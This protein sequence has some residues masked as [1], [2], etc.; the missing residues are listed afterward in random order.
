MKRPSRSLAF[1]A[2]LSMI[3]WGPLCRAQTPEVPARIAGPILEQSR[4]RVEGN[5]PAIALAQNDRGKASGSIQL[6][7]MRVV[8][9]RSAAQQTALD[10]F[11][12]ELQDKSSPNYHKWLTPEEFGRRYGPADSD[13]AAAVAWLQSHGLAVDPLS[14]GRTNI[15]FSGA[16]SQVE[17]AFDTSIH[18]YEFNGQQ[19]YSNRTNPSIPSALAPLI[20]G[21]AHLNTWSPRPS[22]IRADP[23]RMDPASKRLVPIHNAPE[24]RPAPAFDPAGGGNLYLVPGDAATIYDTPN[25]ALNANDSSAIK[26]DGTGVTIGV[27]GTS[28]IKTNTVQN[29]RSNFLGNTVVPI[30]TNIDG[31]TFTGGNTEP[32]IDVEIAGGLAPGATIHYYVANDLLTPIEQ[33]LTDNTVDILAYTYGVCEQFDST[34]DN[35]AINKFWEQAAVQGIA[36]AVAT[37]DS[38]SAGCDDPTDSNGQDTAAAVGGLAVNA[39]AS[40]PYNIA[41]GGTDFDQLDQ[42]FSSYSTSG[43]SAATYYRTALKYIPEATWNDSTQDNNAVA[44]NQPWGVGLSIYPANIIGGGG[45]PSNCAT[46]KTAANVGSCV[47]GY[48][49]P[50]WQRGAGVP[51]DGIRDLPDVSLMAGNG[52]YNAAWLVCDD[53]TNDSTGLPDDCS[54]QS[55][56]GFNFAAYGGTSTAAPAFAGI[57]ALVQQSTGGRLGQA[58]AQLYNLYNG[59]HASQI[60][61]DVTQGN[62]SVSCTQGSPNCKKNI[63]AYYFETGYNATAGYDLATGLGS[64]DASQLISYW[65]TATSG[66]AATVTVTPVTVSI[67]ANQS[68]SVAVTVAGSGGLLAPTGT[69]ALTG[70]GYTSSAETLSNG[71]YT[72]TIPANSLSVGADALTV[73]YS[74]DTNY[75]SA[76]GTANVTVTAPPT[77]TLSATNPSV[78]APGGSAASTVTVQSSSGYTGDVTLSCALTSAPAGATNLPTCSTGSSVSLTPTV[79]TGTGSVSVT[80]TA[81]TTGSLQPSSPA[82][83]QWFRA[84]GGSAVL[85]LLI[86]FV[87]GR[88]RKW[89]HILSAWILAASIGF[90]LVGCGSSS[91]TTTGN[92]GGSSGSGGGT[93]AKTTPTVKVS[94]ASTSIVLNT[95][96]SV[97]LTVT[98]SGTTTPTG[99]ITLASGSYS[100]SA[101]TLIGG[102]ATV[103]I[104]ASTLPVGQN[105]LTASY[106]GDGNFNPA[107]GTA[108]LTVTNPP[109]VGG[110]TPG[111]YTFTV[112]GTGNDAANT[113]A[114]TTFTITVS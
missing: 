86:F 42:S 1:S 36:V 3:F 54:L 5:V 15:A 22:S 57:L 95:T 100:S 33:A 47:A 85:A 29:Y 30:I 8:L 97:A 21:I 109:L 83:L 114:T 6:K 20:Q 106:S 14:P 56:G 40:T 16:V 43:G 48:S 11:E 34:A 105:I 51:A 112:T 74:G 79:T 28:L 32:Y 58:A 31:V 103:T 23:G 59:S 91:A 67:T 49:K 24:R 72:F 45:G 98:G 92:R 94:P 104:P 80:T 37:G 96:V 18:S 27:P 110:T 2:L 77:F 46:N 71:A 81:P 41:V 4:V 76:T 84:A 53:S 61:H 55:N 9:T 73:T 90:V 7:H 102:S 75:A 108:T 44:N 65:N 69:V 111:S 82:D 26:Y 89:R 52:F 99:T 62:N 66:A 12:Q 88:T 93:A 25:P 107:S 63:A 17:E 101:A 70:G 78:A 64:V 39:Y 19:F 113:S 10:R 87:P 60:F 35:A 13:I 38:G 68:L 50:S